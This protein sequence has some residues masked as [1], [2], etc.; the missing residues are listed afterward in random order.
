MSRSPDD[1]PLVIPCTLGW[2][3]PDTG[4]ENVRLLALDAGPSPRWA[5]PHARVAETAIR[6]AGR[7]WE[8][9]RYLVVQVGDRF[10]DDARLAAL[11]ERVRALLIEETPSE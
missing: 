2:A 11:A 1:V 9:D 6:E 5:K 8:G 3:N 4:P 10:V 7:P